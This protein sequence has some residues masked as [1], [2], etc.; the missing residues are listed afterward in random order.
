MKDG[1]I[2]FCIYDFM[3]E[4]G[5]T[6]SE[7]KIYA[8][9]FAYRMSDLGFYYGK[10]SYMADKCGVSLRTVARAIPK[11]KKTGLIETVEKGGYRGLR[12]SPDKIPKSPPRKTVAEIEEELLLCRKPV[13]PKYEMVELGKGYISMSRQQYHALLELVPM[14]T[15]EIYIMK[16]ERF[17]D[18]N[19]GKGISPPH[20]HYRTIKKW[21]IEDLS[22]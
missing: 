14:E 7:V 3:L 2:N 1:K 18:G 10:R 22:V 9:I 11:L 5:M 17:L 6:N 8:F 16:M 13:K 4:F 12:C 20:S 21:I 15:L 19:M